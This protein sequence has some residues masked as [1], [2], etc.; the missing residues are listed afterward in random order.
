M[1]KG[2]SGDQL[3]EIVKNKDKQKNEIDIETE[4]DLNQYVRD[5]PGFFL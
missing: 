4:S 2:S 1:L 5:H 3:N